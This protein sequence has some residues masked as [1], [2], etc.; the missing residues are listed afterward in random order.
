ML[1]RDV[2]ETALT[3][4]TALAIEESHAEMIV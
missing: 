2:I 4:L 1:R 3:A